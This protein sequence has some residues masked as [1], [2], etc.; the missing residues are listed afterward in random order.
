[1]VYHHSSNH[2]HHP[3][4]LGVGRSAGHRQR[5][6]AIDFEAA[7]LGHSLPVFGSVWDVI[8]NLGKVDYMGCV[9]VHVAGMK[10]GMAAGV[11]Y[12]FAFGIG[13]GIDGL[14]GPVAGLS[15][16]DLVIR[17]CLL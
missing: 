4:A 3:L 7:P 1:M 17:P 5:C 15:S 11:G 6:W 2:S 9:F 12:R 8:R 13:Y 10:L 16:I 14:V